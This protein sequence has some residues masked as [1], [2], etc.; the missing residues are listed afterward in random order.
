MHTVQATSINLSKGFKPIG[1]GKEL[2]GP[3]NFEEVQD[4]EWDWN[5]NASTDG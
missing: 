3:L 2:S 4:D 1:A 5:D